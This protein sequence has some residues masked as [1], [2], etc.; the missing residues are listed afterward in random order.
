MRPEEEANMATSSSSPQSNSTAYYR[1]ILSSRPHPLQKT[2]HLVVI[3]PFQRGQEVCSQG[4]PADHW[5]FVVSGA[6]RQCV[7]RPD[8]RR[9]VVDLLLCGD[10]FG[11]T[12]GEEYDF[13]VE[14]IAK[15][16]VLAAYPRRRVE[17]AADSDPDLARQIRRI[18]FDAI[19]RLQSQLLI[20][21]RIT[22]AEKVG[23]FIL[24]MAMRLSRGPADSVALPITRYDIAEY[25][26]VSAETVSRS[27]TE[28]KQRGLIKMSGTRMVNI[29]DRD[30][31]EEC[32]REPM[33]PS[34]ALNCRRDRDV[35]RAPASPPA[36]PYG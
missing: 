7:I 21:G 19:F 1:H 4:Q 33:S 27:L 8:G 32:E 20:L 23:S 24:E 35:L 16:T 5:Y 31:L 14:A 25:L 2:D 3:T 34:T 26:A 28:L 30:A 10:F 29:I 22:A 9:Q 17:M 11:F 15:E 36:P 6:A 18:A 13:S 12:A